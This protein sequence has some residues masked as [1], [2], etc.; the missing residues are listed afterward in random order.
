MR[1]KTSESR[2]RAALCRPGTA[3]YKEL[4]A[5]Y[6]L[7]LMFLPVF[8]YFL[9]FAYKPM[10]GILMAFQDYS[11]SKGIM[12]SPWVGLKH[13]KSFFQS[14]YFTRLIRNTVTISL[15]TIVFGFPAPILLALLINE[16]RKSSFKRCVQTVSYLPHFIS[17]V[18]ICSMIKKFTMDDGI[19]NDLIAFFGG[20]RSNLLNSPSCFVPIYVISDIWTGVG[21]GSIIYLAALSGIS[22]ELY[23]AAEIDGAGRFK[24]LLNVTLPGIMPT[25]I[26]M[27]VLRM[28]NVLSVG[29]EK[30][31]LL[32][33]PMTKKV[34][35]VIS[36]Y[37]YEKGI[38]DQ[39]W[40]FSTAVGLF[41][42]VINFA[43]LIMTNQMSRKL[44]DSSLW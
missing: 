41:N 3:V 23:E 12:G 8:I 24:Q 14:F 19:I 35:D 37:V 44:S 28:G 9:I 25:I 39:S 2:K 13:F 32:Y 33:N 30:I 20:Q 27:F 5:N 1:T 26:I 34:A 31:I 40:S 18:V 11:P 10:Y 7:Y 16:I 43:F 42:S 21:W 29:Y 15:S 36:S 6:E 17:M 4:K 22:S 38:L